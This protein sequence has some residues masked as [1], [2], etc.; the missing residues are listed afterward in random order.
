MYKSAVQWYKLD[1]VV[2]REHRNFIIRK[3]QEEDKFDAQR[4]CTLKRD[5]ESRE[6]ATRER[7]KRR[8]L[9]TRVTVYRGPERL[10]CGDTIEYRCNILGGTFVAK[11]SSASIEGEDGP[12]I[13]L[14]R[15]P[16]G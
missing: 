9:E 4:E 11:V 12:V 16:S 15:I 10:Q 6:Q 1:E 14:T 7:N 8:K 3:K 5:R 2:R 13:G